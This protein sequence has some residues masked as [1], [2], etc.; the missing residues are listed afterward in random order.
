MDLK[1]VKELKKLHARHLDNQLRGADAVRHRQLLGLLAQP[2]R[3][4]LDNERRRQLRIPGQLEVQFQLGPVTLTCSATDFS[5]GGLSLR[6]FLWDFIDGSHVEVINL[7]VTGQDHP[8][9]VKARM[10]WQS[11]DDNEPQVG[12]EF[13]EI[14]PD[15]RRQIEAAFERL[16]I[17]EVERRATEVL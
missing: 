17:E 16:L 10:V 12:L 4:K 11:V 7:H 3:R 1:L 5:P 2:L 6:S 8:V 13:V 15:D 9:S 14:T